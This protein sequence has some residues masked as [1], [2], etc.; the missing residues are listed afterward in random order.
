MAVWVVS[1]KQ[2]YFLKKIFRPVFGQFELIKLTIHLLSYSF[3]S[4]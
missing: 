3:Y 4:V 1:N 2:E